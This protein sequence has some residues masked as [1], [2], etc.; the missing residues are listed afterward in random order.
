[1]AA[2]DM[3]DDEFKPAC[4]KCGGIEFVA[5]N[6]RYVERTEESVAMIVC[7]N[8]DCQAVAGVVPKAEVWPGF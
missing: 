6:N 1:M 2:E 8:L 4:I 7:G 5:V 3:R